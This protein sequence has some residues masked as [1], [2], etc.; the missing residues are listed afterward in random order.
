M[1]DQIVGPDRAGFEALWPELVR[2][3]PYLRVTMV[4][5]DVDQQEAAAAYHKLGQCHI[6][7][8]VACDVRRERIEAAHLV[9]E[10]IQVRLIPGP[11]PALAPAGGAA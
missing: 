10:G 6:G 11:Q 1:R 7:D 8:R 5:I 2:I 3:S 4:A 9:D